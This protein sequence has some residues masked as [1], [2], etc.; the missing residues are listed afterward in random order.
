MTFALNATARDRLAGREVLG[1]AE[2]HRRRLS[3]GTIHAHGRG[4][5]AAADLAAAA[6]AN[7]TDELTCLRSCA[8]ELSAYLTPD[9]TLLAAFQLLSPGANL[10]ARQALHIGNFARSKERLTGY[11]EALW[12]TLHPEARRRWKAAQP[13][14]D[15]VRR[16]RD[17]SAQQAAQAEQQQM[18]RECL[19]AAGRV[20]N[21]WR[22]TPKDQERALELLTE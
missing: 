7:F 17:F 12:K 1:A 21:A 15:P 14:Y 4:D 16:A 5:P 6:T 10:K 8:A 18:Y 22:T 13:L 2:W 9:S 11:T 20:Y 3:T 19:A